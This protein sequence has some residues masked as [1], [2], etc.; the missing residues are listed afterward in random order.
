MTKGVT[1]PI[2]DT[3]NQVSG[4]L[5]LT[6]AESK[7]LIAKAVLAMT[8]V[9]RALEKGRVI[10]ANGIGGCEGAVALVVEDTDEAVQKGFDAVEGVKGEE[11][12]LVEKQ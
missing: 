6:P 2:T 12:V 10:I 1:R 8:Q 4:I 9:K 11:P 5:V 3:D 7:R